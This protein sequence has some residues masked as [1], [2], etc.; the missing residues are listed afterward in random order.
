MQTP[1]PNLWVDGYVFY[2]KKSSWINVCRLWQQEII[3][4]AVKNESGDDAIVA[5]IGE[6]PGAHAHADRDAKMLLAE[7]AANPSF[8]SAKSTMITINGP[9]RWSPKQRFA[10]H[11]RIWAVE[12]KAEALYEALDP[13][14]PEPPFQR[15]HGYNG[16]AMCEGA[17]DILLELGA[18]SADEL[19][20]L[21]RKA[22]GLADVAS[23]K[24]TTC[25]MPA[26]LPKPPDT[27]EEWK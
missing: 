9:S 21:V 8:S 13:R 1:D 10:A 14:G 6:A 24:V 3:R 18:D 26:S 12:G 27:C 23:T 25:L 22:Q 17:W 11:V 16:H 4:F 20:G 15:G 5:F 2:A 19:A 7:R